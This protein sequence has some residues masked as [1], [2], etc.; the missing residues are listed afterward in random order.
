[1][2]CSTGDLRIKRVLYSRKGEDLFLRQQKSLVFF[3]YFC[4]REEE[5][6]IAAAKGTMGDLRIQ[7]VLYSQKEGGEGNSA[8]IMVFLSYFSSGNEKTG[9]AA[10]KCIKGDPRIK[11]VLYRRKE[12][13]RLFALI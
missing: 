10:V 4:S 11:R 13:W 12:G 1:M 8:K 9:L 7:R 2:K 5:I 3:I 6:G